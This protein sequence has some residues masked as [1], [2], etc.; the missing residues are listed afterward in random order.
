MIILNPRRARLETDGISSYLYQLSL[1]FSCLMT[2]SYAYYIRTSV[3][4]WV[5]SK[6]KHICC[7]GNLAFCSR[8]LETLTKNLVLAFGSYIF[9]RQPLNVAVTPLTSKCTSRCLLFELR[10]LIKLFSYVFQTYFFS[11]YD[12]YSK[13]LCHYQIILIIISMLF[14]VVYCFFA[15]FASSSFNIPPL[16]VPTVYERSF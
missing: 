13:S 6:R 5:H 1:K 12:H 11:N 16:V 4:S 2:Y 7:S 10:R 8:K 14:M 9:P 15:I 3:C